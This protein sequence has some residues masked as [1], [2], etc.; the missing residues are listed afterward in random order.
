MKKL[1][2]GPYRFFDSAD[3]KTIWIEDL[4]QMLVFRLPLYEEDA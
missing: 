2:I 1:A 3:H 4:L